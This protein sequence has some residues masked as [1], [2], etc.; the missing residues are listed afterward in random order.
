MKTQLDALFGFVTSNLPARLQDTSGF[1]SWMENIELTVD[2]KKR[3][4]TGAR[5]WRGNAKTHRDSTL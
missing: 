3:R 4:Q 1:D 5:G 2:E